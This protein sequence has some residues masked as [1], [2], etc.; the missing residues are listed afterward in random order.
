MLSRTTLIATATLAAGAAV[1]G[2]GLSAP[3]HADETTYLND[4]HN[5]G[6]ISSG[7]DSD[8]LSGGWFICRE[9]AAGHSREEV[10]AEIVYGSDKNQGASGIDPKQAD[11]AVVYANDDL[12]PA[13]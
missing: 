12:C 3:A 7:G 1:A 2:I 4:M 11:N 8:L 13:A 5:A 6:I 9:L 10:A